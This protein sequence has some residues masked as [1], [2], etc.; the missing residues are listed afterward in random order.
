MYLDRLLCPRCSSPLAG[1]A[2]SLT[3]G[4]CGA[5]YGIVD[6][7]PILTPESLDDQQESQRR[8]FDA[9]FTGYGVYGLENWRLSF[10]ERIFNAVGVLDGRTPYLDIGVGGSGATVI[11]AARRG[12]DAVGC[13]LSM[14][15]VLAASRMAS[16]QGVDEKA[17]FYVCAAESLPFRDEAFAS[18][19]AVAVLEHLDDDAPAIAEIARVLRPVGRVWITVPHAYRY[20]PP[21]IWPFYLWHD[22]RIGHK[23]HYD[24]RRLV[25][26]FAQA[27]LRHVGTHYSGHPVKI[28]QLAGSAMIPKLRRTRSPLWWRLEQLDRRA[29]A[30]KSGA[31]Q[32]NAVFARG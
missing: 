24:E 20:I 14:E 5:A 30:R 28:L 1:R 4:A 17:S 19:S 27:G 26:A 10:I 11:E 15:G 18:A 9:E 23:R 32:L 6:G 3:C 13:D 7:V 16:E 21:P 8:Y 12:V 29:S 31:L 2:G 22:R 25:Q